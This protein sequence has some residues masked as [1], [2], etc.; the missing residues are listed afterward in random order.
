MA[1]LRRDRLPDFHSREGA[2]GARTTNRIDR[3]GPG[4]GRSR[5]LVSRAF[6]RACALTSRAVDFGTGRSCALALRAFRR[7]CAPA[8]R[9]TQRACALTS[10]AVD[11]R[12]DLLYRDILV[13]ATSE[14]LVVWKGWMRVVV[15]DAKRFTDCCGSGV[16]VC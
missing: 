14:G 5:A 9:A 8:S 4:T 15:A 6:R 12:L 2:H 10:R 11:L 13:I 1:A 3:P 16:S 7:A